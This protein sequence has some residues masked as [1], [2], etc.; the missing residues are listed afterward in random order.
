MWHRTAWISVRALHTSS[1][2]GAPLPRIYRYWIDVHGQLFLYDTVPKNLTSCTPRCETEASHWTQDDAALARMMQDGAEAGQEVIWK[3]LQEEGIAWVSPCQGEWN[4]IHAVD[5]PI[6][7]RHLTNDGHLVWGGDYTMPWDPT[8]LRVHPDTGY[9][10]H[11][12]PMPPLRRAK[13]RGVSPYGPYSLIASQVV[14]QHLAD[15]LQ[16]DL[17]AGVGTLTW[18]GREYALGSLTLPN[19]L[20]P[21]G[22]P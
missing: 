7:F 10:Y 6:V 13:A 4:V 1:Q 16:M 2:R 19:D 21:P 9:L 14:L 11:P 20:T 22:P 8:Q 18:R 3:R 17:E 5:T 12:S 15:G